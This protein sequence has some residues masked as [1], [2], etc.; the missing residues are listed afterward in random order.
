MSEIQD[1]PIAMAVY[2]DT[3]GDLH[4]KELFHEEDVQ[5]VRDSADEDTVDKKCCI[6]TGKALA[7]EDYY[8]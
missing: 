5:R 2:L 4:V 7:A 1:K 3:D 8:Q 6:I